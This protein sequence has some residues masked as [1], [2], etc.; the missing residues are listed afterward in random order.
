M[1]VYQKKNFFLLDKKKKKNCTANLK[2]ADWKIS[3]KQTKLN[4]QVI[5]SCCKCFSLSESHMMF[6]LQV[7]VQAKEQA[8]VQ[9]R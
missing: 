7:E 4:C 3:Q 5:K 9:R 1:S 6:M 8:E 2:L